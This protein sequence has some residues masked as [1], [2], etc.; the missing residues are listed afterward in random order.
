MD[1]SIVARRLTAEPDD[2][3]FSARSLYARLEQLPDQRKAR[4]KRYSLALVLT[5]ILLAKLCGE[6]KPAGYA[7]WAQE[8]AELLRPLFALKQP[9]LPHRDTYQRVLAQAVHVPDLER[10]TQ[11]FLQAGAPS[12]AT[13]RHLTM[14]GKTL[15]GTL[16]AGQTHGLQVLAVYAPEQDQVLAQQAVG[17]KNNELRAAFPLLKALPLQ[18]KIVTGDAMFAHRGLSDLVS[19]AGGDYVWL[20]KDNQPRTRQDIALLFAPER[21]APGFSPAPKD[22]RTVRTVTKG[23]G[24]R[25][26]RTLTTSALLNDTLDWPGLGQVFQLKRVTHLTARA[27]TRTEVVYGLT[28]LAAAHASPAQVLAL[29]RDH[30]QIEN[31]LHYRRDVSL[32]EDRCRS[33]NVQAAEAQA[34][35]N[36]LVLTLLLRHNRRVP[37]AQRHFAAHPDQALRLL[38]Q[39]P[40]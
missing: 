31:G 9:R 24:R 1:Y 19:T 16:A 29:L 6:T 13:P 14:D 17:H 15:R 26:V 5:L 28:S 2:T 4:G 34:I 25:E 39:A 33:K 32:G 30:W 10:V 37:Q 38:L 20:I 40:A 35:L 11:E 36:N 27:Q 8:R 23:H 21:C 3:L 7:Q 22:F 12:T 18:G